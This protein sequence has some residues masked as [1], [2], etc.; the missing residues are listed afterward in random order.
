MLGD[1]H[2]VMISVAVCE[3]PLVSSKEIQAVR[4][5]VCMFG[6]HAN[7]RSN[8]QPFFQWNLIEEGIEEEMIYLAEM[9]V[10]LR[11][12]VL[13]SGFYMIIF[14]D[15]PLKTLGVMKTAELIWSLLATPLKDARQPLST[16]SYTPSSS[17]TVFEPDLDLSKANYFFI[18]FQSTRKK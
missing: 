12:E 2:C 13:G 16:S 15:E 14:L 4:G 10:S 5:I 9:N 3:C 17:M 11:N 18:L 8:T 1:L 6:R 7:S